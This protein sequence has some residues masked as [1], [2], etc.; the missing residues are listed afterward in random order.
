MK[1]VFSILWKICL[2]IG[3]IAALVVLPPYLADKWSFK[4][5]KE[6]LKDQDLGE[7]TDE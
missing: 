5:S 6:Y 3:T 1:K 7:D 4:S 2:F